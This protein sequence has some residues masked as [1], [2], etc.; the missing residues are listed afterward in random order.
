MNRSETETTYTLANNV[1]EIVIYEPHP[2]DEDQTQFYLTLFKNGTAE[3]TVVEP[4]D[5]FTLEV[6]SVTRT[7]Y[8]VF[9]KGPACEVVLP[10][11]VV[12]D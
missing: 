1:T 8:G 2:E 9:I 7:E 11:E 6:T 3:L 12:E 10:G 5:T 4:D